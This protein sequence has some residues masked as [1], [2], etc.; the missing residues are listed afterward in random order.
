MIALARARVIDLV[1]PDMLSEELLRV[2]ALKFNWE[3]ARLLELARTVQELAVEEPVAPAT[4]K[5]V[6]GDPDDDRILA[7]AL[8]AGVDAIVTGSRRHLLPLGDRFGVR[9]L[10]P[11]ALIAELRTPPPLQSPAA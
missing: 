4:A 8:D 1:V 2:L 3:S 11:Q 10:T 5:S 6:S 9:I 7:S